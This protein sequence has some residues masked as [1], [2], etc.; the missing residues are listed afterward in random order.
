M[1]LITSGP[2]RFFTITVSPS[3]ILSFLKRVVPSNSSSLR[4][5]CEPLTLNS[6]SIDLG[7]HHVPDIAGDG[8]SNTTLAV[9][10]STS[11]EAPNKPKLNGKPL[12]L[13]LTFTCSTREYAYSQLTMACEFIS[14]SVKYLLIEFTLNW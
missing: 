7:S 12:A 1:L 9:S 4:T 14:L 5:S 6:S 2:V 3:V 8:L 10:F 13:A 11:I